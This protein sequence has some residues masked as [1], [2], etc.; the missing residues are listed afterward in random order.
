MEN[1][2]SPRTRILRMQLSSAL[3]SFVWCNGWVSE[4]ARNS[5]SSIHPETG[6][7]QLSNRA[8]RVDQENLHQVGTQTMTRMVRRRRLPPFILAIGGRGQRRRR[9]TRRKVLGSH[10]TEHSC[11]SPMKRRTALESSTQSAVPICATSD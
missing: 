2:S 9:V 5:L 7:L 4:A 10:V 11:W 6:Y 1:I 3:P 8:Q